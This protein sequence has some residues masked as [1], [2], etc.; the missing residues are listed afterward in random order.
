MA[1][2]FSSRKGP[3]LIAGGLFSGLLYFTYGARQQ[4]RTTATHDAS[5]Q[6]GVS[7]TLQSV[8]GTGGE[9]AHA[10][11]DREEQRLYDPKD[12]G[13]ASSDPSAASKRS[14]QKVRGDLGGDQN[15]PAGGGQGKHI[16][17]RGPDSGDLPYKRMGSQARSVEEGRDKM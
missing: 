3:L 11:R 13:L 17:D 8:A 5:S 6:A 15:N 1:N 12:T 4:P 10:S 16:G 9:R 2:M 14:P 7:Q